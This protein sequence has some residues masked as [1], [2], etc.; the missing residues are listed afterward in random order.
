M[1]VEAVLIQADIS[2][3]AGGKRRSAGKPAFYRAA[4]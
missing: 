1:F 2:G 4:S 3:K